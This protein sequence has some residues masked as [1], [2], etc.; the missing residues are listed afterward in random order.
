[1]KPPPDTAF[2]KTAGL[3]KVFKDFWLRPKVVALEGLDLEILPGEVHGLLGSNGAGKSTTIKLILGLLF[4]TSGEVTVFGKPPGDVETK[5][6]IGYLPEESYLYGF[7][8]AEEILDYYG[9]LFNLPGPTR[10]SRIAELL[11][12]VGLQGMRNR[13]LAEYSK[14]MQRRIGIAQAL[15]NNPDLLILDEPTTGLDPIGAREV[16]DLILR[17]KE[18]GKSVLLSSHRL[19]DVEDVCDRITVLYG[20]CKQAEGTIDE[21]LSS[22]ESTVIETDR[23]DADTLAKIEALL[24]EAGG[25]SIRKTESPRQ[26]LEN[27]FLGLVEKAGREGAETSGATGG[28]G[29]ARFLT[30]ERPAEEKDPPAEEAAD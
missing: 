29:V 10:R 16:K 18:E 3:K 30:R 6:R 13:P 21:L 19:A 14:G 17:L 27:F 9:R 15:I 2:V 23:L 12:M 11:E 22:P 5:N 7:L 25:L 26:S 24:K 28:A 1:M 4:P 8:D 20:G